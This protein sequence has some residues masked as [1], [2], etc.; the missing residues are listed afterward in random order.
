MPDWEAD[1]PQLGNW[2]ETSTATTAYNCYAFAVE[3]QTHWWDPIPAPADM[4]YYWPDGA[5]LDHLISTFIEIYKRYGYAPCA[6][7]TLEPG[8]EKIVIYENAYGGSDHVARQLPDGRWTSKIGPDE[9]I[10]HETPGSLTSQKYGAPR[11]F[12][13]RPNSQ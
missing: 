11:H 1:F 3:D 7:G 8:V 12:M 2:E 9:D 6:D 4:M 5:P 10:S 13:A